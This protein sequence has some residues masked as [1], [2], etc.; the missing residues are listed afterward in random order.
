MIFV[1]VWFCGTANYEQLEPPTAFRKLH[2]R[3]NR[4][5]CASFLFVHQVAELL[6][7]VFPQDI[8]SL[9]AEMLADVFQEIVEGQVSDLLN[10]I[11]I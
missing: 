2:T 3:C 11:A 8:P 6:L 9:L 4:V 5:K 7:Q 10:F 1:L